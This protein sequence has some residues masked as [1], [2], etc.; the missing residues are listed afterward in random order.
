MVICILFFSDS[1]PLCLLQDI[2]HNSMCYTVNLYCFLKKK[3][4]K[5]RDITLPTKLHL[6]KAM[7]VPVGMY[8]CE[9]DYKEG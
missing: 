8:G 1:F 6:V 7:V 9:L 2:E 4:K 3:K 5:S